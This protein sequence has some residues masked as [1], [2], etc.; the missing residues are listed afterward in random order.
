MEDIFYRQMPHSLEAEQS[1][2]GSMLI[3]ANC[4]KDVMEQLRP[5]DFYLKQN[6]EIFETIYSM[7]VYSKP[8]DGVTVAGEMEKN[9]TYEESTTRP[10]LAQLM[11]VT[12]TSAN[13]MEYVG[14]VRDK[15]LLR[16]LYTVAG[17]ISTMVQ[18]GTGGASSVLDAAEQ[19]IYAV[20]RGRSAQSMA[21]IGVV[22]QGVLDHLSEL[23]ANGGKT[24]PGLPTGFGVLDDKMNGLNRSDLVL[25][26]ARPGMGKTSM[27][28]NLA[29]NVARSSGQAVAVFSLEMSREQLVTRILSNQATVENQR[30]VTGNLREQDWVNIANAASVLSGLDILIDDNPLLTVA[31]MNAKCRR[32]DNLGLVVIDYLQLMASSGTKGYSGESRQQVVSDISRMLKIMAKELQVPVLCLSQLSRANEKR[33]D[34]RPMLSDLRE[35]GA[36]EQDADIVMF[37]YRDDYYNEDSEKRNIAECIIAKN[38]HGET[39]KVE[40]SI[41]RSRRSTTGMKRTELPRAEALCARY[42]DKNRPVLAAVS[43]GLD[44][45]CLLHFLRGEGYDVSCAHFN[46]QLRGEEAARDE[47][48]VRAWCEKEGIP[49]YLGTG[50][51]RAHARATGKSE[52]EAARDLRYAFLRETAQ[53]LGAQIALA[54]HAD[55][56]AET[57]LLNFVRGTDLRGLCGM[58]PKQGDI[59]RPF[60]EQTREELV[61]YAR[62]HNIPHVEDHTNA[63]PNAA[64]RNYLRLEILPRLRELNPRAPQHIATTARSLTALDDAL[65]QAAEAALSHA[66]AQDG[67]IS[68]SLDCFLAADEV[69]QPRILLH[70]ADALG[71]GRKD[72][73][74][75]QLDAICA[76]AQRG[77][78]AERRYTLPQSATVRIADGA[79]TMAFSPAALPK[80]AL[81]E[82]VPLPWGNFELTLLH[83]PDGEGISLRVPEDGEIIT[84]APCDLNARL[85]LQGANGA[86]SVKRLCVDRKLSLTER[87]ALPALYVGGRLA[88]V[89]RLGTD[90]TFLPKGGNMACFVRVVPR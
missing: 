38:R 17:E 29:L 42:L 16:A 24:L 15:A 82:N 53:M 88:A 89:W 19:K 72:I 90:V 7:F 31:D 5:D 62:A 12:P 64:A 45:M 27:A 54:H 80:A 70:L 33:E 23:S 75:K 11:D 39:G 43:G 60:L 50:D 46:H 69:V 83:K 1:V 8:I 51:V 10:Y 6:R 61:T 26:A 34:K 48:F 13:V 14:I 85:M 21:S 71:L 67:G 9:G 2:L 55:D 41:R 59:V 32:I 79:L 78:S 77:G 35:S 58:R 25:L 47:D 56:N 18:D 87:D 36:I 68:L 66:K 49:F 73:G 86:R 57:V 65:E 63:D 30:L 52:E 37:L 84:V 4:V 76:L 20:R 22:L 3:D 44:S 40:L 74:R 28:L 81:V